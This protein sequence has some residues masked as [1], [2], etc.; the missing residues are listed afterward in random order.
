MAFQGIDA[1][2]LALIIELQLSDMEGLNKGKSRE[3]ETT[4]REVAMSTYKSELE[5]LATFQ[6][7]RTLCQSIARA[8][9]LDG[10]A[11]RSHINVEQQ[12][13]RDRQQALGINHQTANRVNVTPT[14]QPALGEDLLRRLEGINIYDDVVAE[15]S[16]WAASRP[17]RPGSL[18]ANADCLACGDAVPSSKAVQCPCSHSYCRDCLSALFRSSFTDESLFPPRCCKLKIPIDSAKQHLPLSLVREYRA[19]QIEHG[20][21]NRT[22]CHKATCS[23]FIPPASIEGDTATCLDCGDGTCVFCKG[24]SHA[25]ECPADTV[26][27]EVLR[28][29]SENGWQRCRSCRRM[30]EL[31]TGCNHM[32][33]FQPQPYHKLKRLANRGQPVS[34]AL[35]F[36]MSVVYRGRTAGALSGTRT[37]FSPGP[38]S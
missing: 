9:Q 30:V 25:N 23:A 37:G 27:Q 3:G 31:E 17:S 15:S 28:I 8:V 14:K 21:P 12:A 35:S 22:Y 16:S 33:K 24:Q 20:T 38:M 4:D 13:A 11:I 29:A 6:S 34:A 26:T 5:S 10:D 1:E 18:D 19:K 7:D 32:S 2:S 36:A